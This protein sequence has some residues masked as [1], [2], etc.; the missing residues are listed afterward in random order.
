MSTETTQ[1]TRDPL[2]ALEKHFGHR[3]FL[4][5]QAPVVASILAGQDALVVMPTG[6]GKSLCYQLPAMCMDGV[7]IVVSPLIALMKDQVDALIERG[8][9]AAMINSTLSPDEQSDRIQ[10]MRRGEFKLVYIAPERFRSQ[11][12][13]SALAECSI[14]FFAI[15]EAHCLS[16]WGHD[17]RPDYLRLGGAIEKIGSPQIGA[18]TATAT[19]EVRADIRKVLRLR[20]P[21]ECISGFE[22]PNL[23]LRVTHCEKEAKKYKRIESVVK[24]Y[25]TGIVYCSTRKHVEAVAAELSAWG[26]SAVAYHGGMDDGA[27][28]KAQNLFISRKR[29]VAI[30]TNAFGMGID[31]SDVRFVIHFDIPGSIEAYYQEAGRAGRDGEPAVC[32]LLFNYADTRTQEFFIDGNNPGFNVIQ[33][34]Y[35]VLREQADDKGEVTLP[36]KAIADA[37]MAPND[38]GISSAL[39]ALARAGMIQRFDVPGKRMRGTRLLQPEVDE[40]RLAIDRDALEEKDRRDRAKLKAMID[41]CY[42]TECRQRWILEYFGEQNAAACGSCDSCQSQGSADRRPP[43]HEE[44]VIV[45]KALSGVARMSRRQAGAW[46]GRFGRMKIVNMLVGGRSK[47]I[48]NARLDELTTYGLLKSEGSAYVQTL[49]RELQGAGLLQTESGEFP[50]LTLTERGDQAMRGKLE[51]QINWPKR[52]GAARAVE[53]DEPDLV[54]LDFD[55]VLYEKLRE[56]RAKMA[57]EGGNVPAYVIFSNKTLEFLTRLKPRSIEAGQRIQGIG[58]KRAERYLPAFIEVIRDHT[59]AAS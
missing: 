25:K 8:I 44:R 4:D 13:T 45:Q 33:D 47:D 31:R 53:R 28:E 34:T 11:S 24:R 36:I 10:R 1:Q 59:G 27:R 19:P 39:S 48:L 57:A 5:G 9:P 56:L 51:F 46:R 7:T 2:A 3:K 54:A 29:D 40:H 35:R 38:M 23:A 58:E 22:R 49:L 43:D 26:L 50:L 17:F 32:E 20:N 14:G 52:N 41:L 16:Q 42:S 6:G 15:D 55:E 21:Y 12:F 30:A 18:F 37:V